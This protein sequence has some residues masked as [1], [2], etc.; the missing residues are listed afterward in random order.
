MENT[1]SK[2]EI[3]VDEPDIP[4][5]SSSSSPTDENPKQNSRNFP[6]F[7]KSLTPKEK[8]YIHR[9]IESLKPKSPD[10]ET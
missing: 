1:D 7:R 4:S 10:K 2:I 8:Q 3:A 6:T 5:S 9:Y